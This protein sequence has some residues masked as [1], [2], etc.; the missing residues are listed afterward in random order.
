[1]CPLARALVVNLFGGPCT[2]KSV[3]MADVFARLKI[4]GIEAEQVPEFAKEL[5][6]EG[7]TGVLANQVYVYANQ[8]HRIERVSEQVD[9]AI[10]DSPL[11]LSILYNYRAYPG[12]NELVLATHWGMRTLNVLL[13]R[14]TA[15][16]P[17]GRVHTEE[18]ALQADADLKALLD[19]N[20]IPYT[21][22]R[23][24]SEAAHEIYGLIRGRV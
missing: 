11:L 7:S 5:V 9:V 12:L 10:T 20:N 6:W 16:N 1:M 18:E 15:Y 24:D 3:L 13:E 17:I 4:N 19:R 14:T 2:G 23:V 21:V 8:Y 22:V